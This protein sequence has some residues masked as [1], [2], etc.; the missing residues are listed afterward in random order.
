M[1]QIAYQ[2]AAQQACLKYDFTPVEGGG[3]SK[4]F[5][6]DHSYV[7]LVHLL[8]N[9]NFKFQYWQMKYEGASISDQS[10]RV[11][12]DRHSQDLHSGFGHHN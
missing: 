1:R 2:I 4:I 5:I 7:S 6:I 3:G 10:D 8:W 11:L 12:T 9:R